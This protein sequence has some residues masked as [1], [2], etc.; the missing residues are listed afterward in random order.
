VPLQGGGLGLGELRSPG[1]AGPNGRDGIDAD[2]DSV[3]IGYFETLQLKIVRGRAFGPQD[4]AS[5]PFVAIVNETMAAR[6]WPGRDP[7]G[8]TLFQGTGSESRPLQIVGVARDSKYRGVTDGPRNFIYVP[9]AQQFLSEVTFYVR[10][11]PAQSR[12][13]DLRRAVAAYDPM[14]P[15]VHTDTLEKATAIMLLPQRIAAWIAGSVGTLGLFLAALGLYGL[16][17]FSVSQRKRE[18]AIRLAVGASARSVVWLV[19]RQATVLSLVG[20][21]VGLGLAVVLSQLIGSFLVGLRPIDPMAFGFAAAVLAGVMC[22]AAWTPAR[23]A[24]HMDP[25]SSLRAD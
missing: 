3:S 5:A 4:R 6:V 12:I 18:I 21:G 7:V 19:L 9:M 2:W 15:I 25:V 13:N 17:A 14:L 16:I 22:V 11:D 20:A 8:Q 10:R 24:A 1:Y 23:R